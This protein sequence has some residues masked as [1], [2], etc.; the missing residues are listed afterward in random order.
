M[1]IPRREN[2]VSKRREMEAA[3]HIKRGVGDLSHSSLFTGE[4]SFNEKH[5]KSWQMKSRTPIRRL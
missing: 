1:E 5:A 4:G 3:E 2:G